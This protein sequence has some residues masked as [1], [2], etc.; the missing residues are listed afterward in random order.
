M[1]QGIRIAESIEQRLLITSLEKEIAELKRPQRTESEVE[2]LLKSTLEENAE[3][4][5]TLAERT[6]SSEEQILKRRIADFKV[7]L[8]PMIPSLSLNA[9]FVQ[10]LAGLTVDDGSSGSSDSSG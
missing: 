6:K 10:A 3:L 9:E 1:R 4:K 5:R 2:R 8:V 7:R